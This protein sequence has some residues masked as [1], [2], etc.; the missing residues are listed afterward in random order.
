MPVLPVVRRPNVLYG[1]VVQ[2]D[3]HFIKVN[4][5]DAPAA[6]LRNHLF[7]PERFKALV[8]K[9]YRQGSIVRLT[10]EKGAAHCGWFPEILSH[11]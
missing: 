6:H 8:N 7:L 2:I 4:V 9:S 10:W 3:A 1:S 11:E 5:V